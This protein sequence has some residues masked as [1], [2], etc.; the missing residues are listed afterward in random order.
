M[1]GLPDVAVCA[2]R[3]LELTCCG[4]WVIRLRWVQRVPGCRRLDDL[5]AQQA[6]LALND[7]DAS[8]A[9]TAEDLAAVADRLDT[10]IADGQPEQT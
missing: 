4:A 1:P 2:P 7:G 9:P 10:L 8:R 5:G 6:E 3:S